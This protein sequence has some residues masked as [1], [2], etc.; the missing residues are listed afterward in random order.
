[1]L[2]TTNM[3]ATASTAPRM[4]PNGTATVVPYSGQKASGTSVLACG[5][6]RAL[7]LERSR[8]YDVESKMR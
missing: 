8:Q 2:R 5:K 6:T 4:K 1:M 3:R 7:W